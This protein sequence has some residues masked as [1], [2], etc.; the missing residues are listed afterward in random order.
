MHDPLQIGVYEKQQP[1]Y[2]EE[3][4]GPVELGRQRK[5]EEGPYVHKRLESGHWRLV[6]A[7]SDED[8]VSREH[9]LLEPLAANR[10]R[11]KNL[12][13]T[14]PIILPDQT[15]LQ[16]EASCELSLPAVLSI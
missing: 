15:P 6:I 4:D 16:P 2:Q 8:S 1:V 11:L 12:S 3:F 5:Q 7:R 9:A 13:T 10:I 14:R